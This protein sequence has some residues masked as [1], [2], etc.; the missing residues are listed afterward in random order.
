MSM[1]KAIVTCVLL[2]LV[3]VHDAA[4]QKLSLRIDRGVVSLDAENV[5]V[6]EV[7]A[8]WTETT[9]LN[10]ISKGGRGSETRVS[11]HLDGTT[12][13][14]ALSSVLRDLSGYIMGERRDPA[15]GVVTVDRLMI[16]P[17]S[18]EQPAPPRSAGRSPVPQ[19]MVPEVVY[20]VIEAVTVDET[21]RE[22]APVPEEGE[23]GDADPPQAPSA[24]PGDPFGAWK[25]LSTPGQIAPLAGVP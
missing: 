18:D 11:L 8:R 13:R 7:L 2:A 14:E 10:I 6:D 21:P 9:G 22:L 3:S 20:P 25:G 24:L 5:T 12:E 23:E 19:P 4:A 15:S 1:Q 17:Q 16:L